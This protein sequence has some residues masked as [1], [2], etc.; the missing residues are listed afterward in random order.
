MLHLVVEVLRL[1]VAAEDSQQKVR[2]QYAYHELQVNDGKRS[3]AYDVILLEGRPYRRLVE[4]NGKA[5]SEKEAREVEADM[6]KTSK[7]RRRGGIFKRVY[8]MNIGRLRDLET[9][10]ELQKEGSILIASPKEK[11]P[12]RHRIYFDPDSHVITCH[13]VEVVGPGSELKPGT[14]VKMDYAREAGGPS[15]LRK[16]TI[17]FKVRFDTGEQV[18][19]Y[20]RY[21]KFDSESTITF[22]DPK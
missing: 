8:N 21:R 1:I 22:E 10:H 13:E 12:Y 6:L 20:S 5:L 18:H 4:K 14:H 15:L 11:G 7:A 2:E 9:T 16:M 17:H 19:T 3:K